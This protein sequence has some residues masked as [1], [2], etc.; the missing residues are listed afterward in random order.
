MKQLLFLFFMGVFLFSSFSVYSQSPGKINFQSILR[1]TTGEI[2]SN[3]AVSIRMSIIRGTINGTSVYVETHTKTTDVSGLISIKLGTGTVINGI[4]GNIEWG[5][6]SHF[7]QLEVDFDG[8]SNY[9]V[10]GTQ[11][12]ISVPYALYANKTDTSVLNLTSRFS[13]KLNGTDTASMSNRIDAKANKSDTSLLNLTSRFSTK[14]NVTDTASLSNRIDTKLNVTDSTN[15]LLPYLRDADTTAMLANYRTGINAKLNILDTTSMLSPYL[16]RADTTSMLL[17]YLRDA[18][19]TNMLVPYLRDAD[20]TNML[21]SYFKKSDTTSL[22]LINRF[23]EKLNIT[24][25]P[26]GATTGNIMFF[27][28]SSW[29][30]LAPGSPG[31]FLIISSNGIPTW[32]CIITNTAG[33][34][35]SSPSLFVNTALTNITISTTGATGIGAATGL[36]AGVTASWSNNVITISGTPTATGSFTYTIPLTGGCGSV[37]AT[38]TITVT[39]FTCG[40]NT[41]SDIDGNTYNTVTLGSQCWIT[42]NLK[43]SRYR[44]GDLIPSGFNN[45]DWGNLTTGGRSWWNNDSTTYEIPYGNLYN[46]YAVEDSRGLCPTGW[47][48]PSDGEWTTMTNFLSPDAANKLKS[49]GTDYWS[50]TNAG[51]TNVT[52]FSAIG[53]GARYFNGDF[54]SLKVNGYV[55]SSTPLDANNIYHRDFRNNNSNVQRQSNFLKTV[56]C[57]VRCLKD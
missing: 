4:F 46:W 9:V 10:I 28:G 52:G 18:D 13:M 31:Q 24:D 11:E 21:N 37:N 39:V 15:M 1:N 44:N 41:V 34:P 14:L 42:G 2:V 29:E 16:R 45:T 48:V 12:L 25:F 57:S 55:W 38:G 19:T 7:I 6:A 32:G 30:N 51:V 40:T 49:T 43:T 50:A 54:I 47:H 27:N 33:S 53:N 36:P 23:N 8:G 5:S 35:S 56:G 17:P 22:N 26:R 3:K 20:T